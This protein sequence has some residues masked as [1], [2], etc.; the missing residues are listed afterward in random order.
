MSGNGLAA[1]E[2]DEAAVAAD[3]VAEVGALLAAP[4]AAL[5]EVAA[6]VPLSA[7][8]AADELAVLEP[9]VE[10][11]LDWAE[12]VELPQAA[13]NREPVT[14]RIRQTFLVRTGHSSQPQ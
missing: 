4:P 14:A 3:D 7:G 1:D 10:L 8:A 11:E 13:T 2:A 5:P 9:A 6:D 12:F